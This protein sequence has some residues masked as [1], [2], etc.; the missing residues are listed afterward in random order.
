MPP[1]AHSS[2]LPGVER[3]TAPRTV[4]GAEAQRGVAANVSYG[5][6]RRDFLRLS[7]LD[8]QGQAYQGYAPLLVSGL[9]NAVHFHDLFANKE[10]ALHC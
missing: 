6:G 9:V 5:R 2:N 8:G 1:R 10:V 4:H 3:Q 7:C